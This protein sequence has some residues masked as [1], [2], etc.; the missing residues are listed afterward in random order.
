MRKCISYTGYA[1]FVFLFLVPLIIVFS[2][3]DIVSIKEIFSQDYYLRVFKFTYSQ[4]IISTFF[5]VL[6]GLIGAY[7][8]SNYKFR[9]KKIIQT[10]YSIPIMLPSVLAVL[11]FV[12]TFGTSGIISKLF[13]VKLHF[14]YSYKAII[15]AHVFYNFPIIAI[16][17]SS[18][19]KN[20]GSDQEDEARVAGAGELKIFTEITLP[21]LLPSILSSGIIVLMF[22]ISSFAIILILGGNPRF[23]NTEVEIYRQARTNLNLGKACSISLISTAVNTFLIILSRMSGK[24]QSEEAETFLLKQIKLKD[25]N[26]FSR[27]LINTFLVISSLFVLLPVISVVIKSFTAVSS[28]AGQSTISVK[29]YTAINLRSISETLFIGLAS[30]LFTTVLALSM[31]MDLAKRNN[32]FVENFIMLPM[33]TSSVIVG[34]SFFIVS[35]YYKF[36]PNIL[37]VVLCHSIVNIPISF[38]IIL[39]AYRDIPK[40][41]IEAAMIDGANDSA[42]IRK[43]EIPAIKDSIFASF[44]ITFA[45]SCGELNSTLILS[46][47]KTSTIPIQIQR[48]ISSYNYPSACAYGTVLLLLFSCVFITADRIKYRQSDYS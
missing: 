36:L 22:C 6:I 28:R 11:G 35:K 3:T 39:P 5:S 17:V 38:K 1:L 30:A 25:L 46:N 16:T 44:I 34:L 4:A 24:S 14:L 19:W 40:A 41:I 26:L 37:L 9:F 47:G 48:L 18:K 32:G 8:L 23:T 7:I 13:N 29:A 2:L 31:S 42:I 33:I 45:L 43:I 15:A 12:I 21:K 10:V 27:V 20:I